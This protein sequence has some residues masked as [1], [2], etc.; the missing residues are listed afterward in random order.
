MPDHSASIQVYT[1][2]LFNQS[3]CVNSDLCE[4]WHKGHYQVSCVKQW[5][6]GASKQNQEWFQE[7]EVLPTRYVES[8]FVRQI[9]WWGDRFCSSLHVACSATKLLTSV[10]RC[11]VKMSELG[12]TLFQ[13]YILWSK[14]TYFTMLARS[15]QGYPKWSKINKTFWVM[16]NNYW[17]TFGNT[18]QNSN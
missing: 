10:A 16:S 7:K 3:P 11:V 17:T 14:Q 15:Q 13:V 1:N 12:A 6:F 5:R 4:L 2:S 8:L 18:V 9:L